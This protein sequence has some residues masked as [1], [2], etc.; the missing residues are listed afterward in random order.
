V[1]ERRFHPDEATGL[2]TPSPEEARR[3]PQ[4]YAGVAGG[5]AL[6]A[7][8]GWLMKWEGVFYEEIR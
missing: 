6:L 2:D 5:I 7:L 3:L 4:L 1:T 8:V